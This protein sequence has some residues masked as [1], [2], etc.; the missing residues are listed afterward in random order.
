MQKILTVV[1]LVVKQFVRHVTH[2]AAA[3]ADTVLGA[4][5]RH[6][7]P[8]LDARSVRSVGHAGVVDIH[9]L[10]PQRNRL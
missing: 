5:R 3:A 6:A 7:G 9:V 8:D 1:V 4:A 10:H 2:V